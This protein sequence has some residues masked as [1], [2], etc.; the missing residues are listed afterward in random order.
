M[1]LRTRLALIVGLVSLGGGAALGVWFA[2][3]TRSDAIHDLDAIVDGALATVRADPEKDPSVLLIYEDTISTP[4]SAHVLFD[5]LPPVEI[6]QQSDGRLPVELPN[7]SVEQLKDAESGFRETTVDIPIR[8][9]ALKIEEG[10]WVV[11]AV[12]MREIN[13][14]FADTYRRAILS[15]IFVGTVISLLISQLIRREMQPIERITEDAQKISSGDFGVRLPD[16]TH[17]TELGRLSASLTTMINSLR[18]AIEVKEGAD[19]KMRE[20][21]GDASHE[22]RTP[23]TV[24]R[25]YVDILGSGRELSVEQRNRALQRLASESRRMDAIINDLLLLA[26]MGEVPFALN[27]SVDM[28]SIVRAFA[29]DL[30]EQEPSRQIRKLVDEGVIVQGNTALIERLVA[31][32]VSNVR[33]HTLPTVSVDF[34]LAI[35]G[36]HAVLTVDDNGPGLSESLYQR[37]TEGFQ[38]FDRHRSAEGGGFGLGLSIISSIVEAHHGTFEM[39]QSSLG[40]LCTRITLPVRQIANT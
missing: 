7:L 1:R 28:T 11:V 30:I 38:R 4:I 36:A 16:V 10:Q 9:K 19:R 27:E 33:Q 39:K 23:L 12:S 2:Y 37:A 5:D 26:E 14:Q 34:R 40:G 22:L 13:E 17:R 31:N 8:Y 32:L 3:G 6:L 35:E 25:G 20:F 15:S 21:L 24:I 29:R 18:S